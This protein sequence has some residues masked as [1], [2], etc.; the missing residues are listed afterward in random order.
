VV[1]LDASSDDPARAVDAGLALDRGISAESEETLLDDNPVLRAMGE[2]ARRYGVSVTLSV[3]VDPDE[4]AT[5][6]DTEVGTG[7]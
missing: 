5:A 1:T 7:D 3:Y 2:I 6:D 4:T